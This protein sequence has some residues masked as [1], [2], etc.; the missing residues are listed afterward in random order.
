M[1][2]PIV[3]ANVTVVTGDRQGTVIPSQDVTISADGLIERIDVAAPTAPGHGRRIDLT[4]A[5]LTPGLINAHVHLFSDGKPLPKLFINEKAE[6]V[7]TKVLHTP[8][9]RGVFKRRAKTNVVTQMLSGVTTLRSVGDVGYVVTE[10]GR[11][12]ERGDYLGPRML[13]SGPLLAIS[14]GHGSPQVALVSDSPWDARRNA[15]INIRKGVSAIKIA[16]TGGITDARSVGEA[17]R[18]QMTQ[19]EMTGICDEAHKA[20][21]LV[22]AH[23]QGP[24]G[25]L[26]AL[27]AGVD[28]IEHGSAMTPEMIDLFHG[29]PRSLRGFS[30]LIPTLQAALP[31][32]KIDQRKTGISDVARA[33]AEMV[34]D[35]MVRAIDDAI[36]NDIR[37]GIGTDAALTYV[38]HYNTWRELDYLVRFAGMTPAHALH[39]ATQSNAEILGL[40][41]TTGTIAI[42]RAADCVVLDRNPLDDLRTFAQPRAVIVRGTYVDRPRIRKFANIDAD[43][44]GI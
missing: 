16:A 29:N 26:S 42:G 32:V 19:E 37:V 12:V 4:G 14:G 24:E 2:E 31:L 38:T 9:G 23:A 13:A 21:I 6:R 1:S 44:D 20:N 25:V 18:P 27:R 33:N 7:L 22:A 36:R 40:A 28:T 17:G 41:E 34:L 11:E 3:L 15:R 35:E 30:A 39:A 10:V 43:L 8:L 5:F